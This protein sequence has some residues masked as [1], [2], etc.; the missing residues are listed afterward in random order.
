M[1]DDITARGGR[2][3]MWK[4]GHSLIKT[5]MKEEKAVLAGE[6]SGHMFF[7]DRYFGFDDGV[8]AAARVVELLEPQ[9]QATVGHRRCAA[10]GAQH[11]RDPR[12]LP[13][14]LQVRGGQACAH[15]LPGSLSRFGH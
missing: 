8:Y 12:G 1:Y 11:T 3:I 10:R 6:M 13:R 9:R 5:K 15:A 7:A 2:A 4:V 14:R